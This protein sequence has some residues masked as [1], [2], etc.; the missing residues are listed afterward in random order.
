MTHGIELEAGQSRHGTFEPITPVLCSETEAAW[1]LS[2]YQLLVEP[3][4]GCETIAC[5]S[6]CVYVC[7]S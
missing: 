2:R 5:V 7:P 6:V 4:N 3:R 1:N